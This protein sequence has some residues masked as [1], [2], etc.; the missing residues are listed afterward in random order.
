MHFHKQKYDRI[1]KEDNSN[2]VGVYTHKIHGRVFHSLA[3]HLIGS[4]NQEPRFAQIYI[5]DT[6]YQ[7]DRRM[8]ILNRLDR[9]IIAS[10]QAMMLRHNEFAALFQ[11]NSISNCFEASLNYIK[12]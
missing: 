3:S 9:D 4:E 5:Y 1:F 10:L 12:N 11:D 2:T 7:L 6:S 8:T